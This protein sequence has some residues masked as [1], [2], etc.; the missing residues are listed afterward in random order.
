MAALPF[1][2][3]SQ[4]A[5]KDG[6]LAAF[7]WPQRSK[8]ALLRFDAQ[9]TK[10]VLFC[11]RAGVRVEVVVRRTR[12]SV[13]PADDGGNAVRAPVAL[14]LESGG[15]H[16][17]TLRSSQQN[18]RVAGISEQNEWVVDAFDV[19]EDTRLQVIARCA[20][21]SVEVVLAC[22]GTS[23]TFSFSFGDPKS[24]RQPADSAR[25]DDCAIQYL[26]ASD[27]D[28]ALKHGMPAAVLRRNR[29]A[30]RVKV[31]ARSG[32]PAPQVEL[33]QNALGIRAA[34]RANG[35][36]VSRAIA[37]VCQATNDASLLWSN[38]APIAAFVPIASVAAL[39]DSL[40]RVPDGEQIRVVQALSLPPGFL[41]GPDALADGLVVLFG[42]GAKTKRTT[43]N[44]ALRS[45]PSVVSFSCANH[46]AYAAQAVCVYAL[47][48]QAAPSAD[49]NAQH[50][51]AIVL[52]I[53]KLC[54]RAP[55]GT[56]PTSGGI[57]FF[58]G[59]TSVVASDGL[60]WRTVRMRANADAVE[61]LRAAQDRVSDVV[62]QV[63]A[64]APLDIQYCVGNLHGRD[65]H[66]VLSDDG[67]A[68]RAMQCS[69]C[70][71]FFGQYLP[72]VGDWARA[73]MTPV[74]RDDSRSAEQPPQQLTA[75]QAAAALAT[76]FAVRDASTPVAVLERELGTHLPAPA[77][78]PTPAPDPNDVGGCAR[79]EARALNLV[80][81][82]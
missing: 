41:V 74:A 49:G 72:P 66:V 39:F 76:R 82:Q 71:A 12:N 45:V 24:A 64:R 30:K 68:V 69:N 56:P 17:T 32:S 34:R 29:A 75:A 35:D 79:D 53:M 4:H 1:E 11:V 21:F 7:V 55:A 23:K 6:K 20:C 46:H 54:Q 58:V 61:Q 38:V 60:V 37:A 8:T 25:T 77:L 73:P 15:A 63:T 18:A 70:N 40:G 62:R 78:A 57:L 42:L 28:H 50:D 9:R 14:C 22:D 67:T 65:A 3:L 2:L 10:C 31:S 27:V 26:G 44:E 5:F 48:Y 36:E 80:D 13:P 52:E 51:A 81:T 43:L 47:T 33:V 59:A 19:Q 16:E